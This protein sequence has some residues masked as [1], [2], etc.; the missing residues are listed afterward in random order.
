MKKNTK[1][2]K[3]KRSKLE[4]TSSG[5]NSGKKKSKFLRNQEIEDH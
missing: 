1:I 5:A 2:G 3:T 4:I